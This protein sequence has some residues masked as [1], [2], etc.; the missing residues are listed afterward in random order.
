[1]L[2]TMH[3]A[4]HTAVLRAGGSLIIRQPGVRPEGDCLTIVVRVTGQLADMPT[5]GLPTCGL[6]IMRTRQLADWTSHG[7]DTS[8]MPPATLHA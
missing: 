2:T 6:D 7:L 3:L 5:R 1:M 4:G 8:Q